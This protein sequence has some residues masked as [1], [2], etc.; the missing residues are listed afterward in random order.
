MEVIAIS[1]TFFLKKR[2]DNNYFK[3]QA[4]STSKLLLLHSAF[5]PSVVKV[6]LKGEVKDP[7]LNSHGNYIVDRGKSWKNHGTVFLNFCGNPGK[8]IFGVSNQVRLIPASKAT[9]TS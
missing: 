3:V 7:A 9:G 2:G 4:W 6:L 8:S 1:P 5:M